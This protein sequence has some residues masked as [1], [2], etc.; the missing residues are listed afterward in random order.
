LIR[1][2]QRVLTMELETKS[3]MLLCLRLSLPSFNFGFFDPRFSWHFSHSSGW[4]FFKWNER[5]A[6]SFYK[7]N[8]KTLNKLNDFSSFRPTYRYYFAAI[9]N[10]ALHLLL[11]FVIKLKVT[12]E[13]TRI[14]SF[15]HF[16][17]S[18]DA[19]FLGKLTTSAPFL[20]QHNRF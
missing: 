18:L 5:L 10:N 12:V 11:V 17:N 16:L 14:L 19:T 8:F 3:L 9:T 2:R 20:L 13:W 4:A 6:S 7:G 1:S 15:K